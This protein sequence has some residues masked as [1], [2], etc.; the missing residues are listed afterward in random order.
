MEVGTGFS[1]RGK[2]ALRS[3]L[4]FSAEMASRAG[5]QTIKST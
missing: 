2:T 4:R 1:N 3:D 5:S